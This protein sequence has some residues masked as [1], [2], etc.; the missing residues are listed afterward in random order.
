MDYVYYVRVNEFP[1]NNPKLQFD[2]F[3]ELFVPDSL[4]FSFQI[5]KLC[6]EFCICSSLEDLVA[7]NFQNG[8]NQFEMHHLTS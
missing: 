7:H 3:T 8:F 1:E 2:C 5:H 6:C 4:S